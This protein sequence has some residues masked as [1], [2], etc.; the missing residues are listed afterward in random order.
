MTAT[1]TLTN[2][3]RTAA[4]VRET[5]AEIN[6]A[7]RRMAEIRMGLPLVEPVRRPATATTAAQ[8]EAL[9]EEDTPE[10]YN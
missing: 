3:R 4:R 2:V 8:L 5:L 7:Q 6:Y 9:Y 1:T 10:H